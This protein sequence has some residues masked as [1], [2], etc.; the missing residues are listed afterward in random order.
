MYRAMWLSVLLFAVVLPLS[1]AWLTNVPQ[2][3]TQPDGTVIECFASGDEFHNW[4]HDSDNYT[5]IQDNETGYYTYAQQRGKELAP[6]QFIVGRIN[7]VLT[8][9]QPGLNI[10]EDLYKQKRSSWWQGTPRSQR[11][12]TSG[13]INNL[14]VFIR[15]S[16]QTEFTVPFTTYNTM[17]NS[18]VPGTNSM[19]NYFMEDSYGALDINTTFYPLPVNNIV[20]SFQD[21]LPRNYYMPYSTTNTIGYSND[22]E[23]RIREHTLLV[24]AINYI[25]PQVPADLV[26]DAD[27]DSRVDNVCFI[28]KGSSG[29]W[30]NLLWPHM[31]SLY[32]YEVFLNGARVYT[33]NFQLENSLTSSGVGVLC[34]EMSHSIGMPD[35]Y[36]YTSNGITPIGRWDLMESNRNPPQHHTAYM[37]HRYTDWL[38]PMR[39]ITQSGTYWVNKMLIRE[40]NCYKIMANN[41]QFY[42]VV[43][44]RKT[45]GTFEPS[46]PGSGLLVYRVD[47]SED[48]D[49]NADGPPDELYAYRPGGTNTANGTINSAH[50]SAEVYR[51][52]INE[53]TSPSPFLPDGSQGGLNITQIGSSAGD[54]ISFVVTLPPV[55]PT[56]YDEGFESGDFSAFDWTFSGQAD[57]TIS[58]TNIYEGSFC[59]RSG[60]IGHNQNSSMQIVIDVPVSGFIGFY[61]KVSSESNYDYLKFYINDVQKGQWS[62]TSNWSYVQYPVT[63]G[64]QTFRWSYIKDQGVVSGSDCAWVDNIMFRWSAPDIHLTPTDF[65]AVSMTDDIGIILNWQSP[66]QSNAVLN[67][68]RIFRDNVQIADVDSNVTSYEDFYVFPN[69]TY[70]YY[71]KAFYIT[72]HGHSL[73]TDTL[74]VFVT[75]SAI[76]PVIFN[77]AVIDTNDVYLQWM[78]PM[79][80]RGITGYHIYR[81]GALVHTVEDQAVLEWTDLDL[82]VGIYFYQ[83]ATRY[84]AVVSDLSD[85]LLVIIEEIVDNQDQHTIPLKFMI[86][87]IYPNPFYN[88]AQIQYSV[89]KDN[90]PVSMNVYNIKGQ[91]VKTLYKNTAKAGQYD[92]LW[93]GLDDSGQQVSSGIY[94]IRLQNPAQTISRKVVLF[95]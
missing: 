84:H 38:P 14:V 85:S 77:A 36:H 91:K 43:E 5:I 40:D 2:E 58:T 29:A 73:P 25:A 69:R 9:L 95:K 61:K 30:A 20:I 35:L 21:S 8:N 56:D 81:N 63:P 67:G 24:N 57:W 53:S 70:S 82:S 52:A 32:T 78:L 13:L 51:T 31:W 59:A 94:F 75:G 86:N 37:K 26:V 90:T 22:T 76:V 46:L 88:S 93:D 49:G 65:S 39:Q 33:Y 19:Y 60:E 87:R 6:S 80:E 66:A 17:F 92:L 64:N 15:F 68:F 18:I 41:P 89:D 12:P 4:L 74:S 55:P 16:D 48:G 23:R 27:N 71:L 44:F 79:Q 54:S 10:S 7:P 50:Y 1:A 3:I 28:I 11:T 47:T 42:Y 45:E 34:H 83:V 72:P 62:G